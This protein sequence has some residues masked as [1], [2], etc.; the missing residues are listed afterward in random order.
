ML[1]ICSYKESL[2]SVSCDN[3]SAVNRIKFRTLHRT[4]QESLLCRTEY[5]TKTNVFAVVCFI[6]FLM[7]SHNDLYWT[8]WWNFFTNFVVL[9]LNNTCRSCS[10]YP[11]ASPTV[12]GGSWLSARHR[13]WDWILSECSWRFD[14]WV[15]LILSKLIQLYD[16]HEMNCSFLAFEPGPHLI[17]FR[18]TA[19]NVPLQAS[20]TVTDGQWISYIKIDLWDCFNYLL[21][22]VN[23]YCSQ[24]LI[25]LRVLGN[26]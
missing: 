18:P 26:S 6:C 13:P 17:S 10:W 16:F 15:P 22:A 24:M 21:F 23:F 5:T 2:D 8:F 19:R 4:P 11:F 12:E 9:N 20:M 1:T 3:I 14:W 7:K 25:F